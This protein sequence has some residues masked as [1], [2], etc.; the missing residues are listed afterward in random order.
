LEQINI[1]FDI[2]QKELDKN[3]SII[4]CQYQDKMLPNSRLRVLPGQARLYL[5]LRGRDVLEALV[6]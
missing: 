1:R 4:Q 3:V 2:W 5:P 6:K